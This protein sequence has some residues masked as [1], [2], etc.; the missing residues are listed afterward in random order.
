MFH[1]KYFAVMQKVFSSMY[2]S[3]TFD[4]TNRTKKDFL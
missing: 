3:L 1:E 2:F 4:L